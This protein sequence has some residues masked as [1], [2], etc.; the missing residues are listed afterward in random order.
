MSILSKHLA[1]VNEQ[2]VFHDKSVEKFGKATFRG[3]LHKSTA[4]KF[5]ALADDIQIA[6]SALDNPSVQK[7]QPK[8]DVDRIFGVSKQ[9]VT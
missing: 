9:D 5:R 6:D 1:F 7:P 8:G 2:I 4:D 3:N